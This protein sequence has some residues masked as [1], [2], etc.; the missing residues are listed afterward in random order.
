MAKAIALALASLVPFATALAVQVEVAGLFNGKAI[1]IIDGGRPKTLAN[2]ESVGTV[3]LIS[4]TSEIAT[5]EIDGKRRQLGMGSQSFGGNF[6][7][8]KRPTVVLNADH[9]GH[10]MAEGAINGMPIRFLVDT[11]ATMVSLGTSDARRLGIDYTRGERGVSNTANGAAIVYRVKL[12]S[13]KVGGIVQN[14]VDAL[15]HA[16]NDMPFALLGMSFLNRLDLRNQGS[17]LTMTL[18]Y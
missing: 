4:A 13:V 2:G 16:G 6:D 5:F 14:N 11:G 1:V 8:G 9:G 7:T 18:R 10:Y 15:V 12:D 3:K 17:Q